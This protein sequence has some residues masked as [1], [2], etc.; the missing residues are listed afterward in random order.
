M[1]RVKW[2]TGYNRIITQ[3]VPPLHC[4]SQAK[5]I[6]VMFSATSL[7]SSALQGPYRR[8]LPRSRTVHALVMSA[9]AFPLSDVTHEY[10]QSRRKHQ[11]DYSDQ[12]RNDH[13]KRLASNQAQP[14]RCSSINLPRPERLFYGHSYLF[15][16]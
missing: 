1:W 2:G 14:G 4:V 12:G 16:A 8:N 3:Q 13:V 15:A 7:A 10:N 6:A 5:F 9:M 11:C